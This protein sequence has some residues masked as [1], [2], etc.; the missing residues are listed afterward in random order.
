VKPENEALLTDIDERFKALY[1]AVRTMANEAE[2]G[3]RHLMQKIVGEFSGEVAVV[4]ESLLAVDVPRECVRAQYEVYRL[5]NEALTMSEQ[6]A[7][8]F[9][10][11]EAAVDT[12]VEKSQ[13]GNISISKE[14]VN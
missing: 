8:I 9:S 11:C 6:S 2:M 13:K 14:G 10:A 5:L 3:M 7:K 1:P 4:L 12:M